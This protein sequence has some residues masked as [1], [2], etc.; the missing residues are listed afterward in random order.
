MRWGER[1]LRWLAVRNLSRAQKVA[2]RH[3]TPDAMLTAPEGSRARAWQ[4]EA[5]D[6][7]RLAAQTVADAQ[8]ALEAGDRES[9]ERLAKLA[10]SFARMSL[11]ETEL[12]RAGDSLA[13]GG[14][15]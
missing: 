14:S 13:P 15:A 7:A 8:A 4:Q 2:A 12:A 5:L 10:A 11:H 3:F 9:A 6:N 1:A